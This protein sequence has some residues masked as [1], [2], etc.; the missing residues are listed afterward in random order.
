MIQDSPLGR[1]GNYPPEYTPELLFSID[2]AENRAALGIADELPFHGVDLWNAWELT[3]LGNNGQPRIACLE[4]RVPAASINIIES[5]SLK[6]YLNSF[7]MSRF[8]SADAVANRVATDLSRAAGAEVAVRLFDAAS[9]GDETSK[10]FPGDC[11]DDGDTACGTWQVDPNLLGAN[12]DTV[13]D[14]SLHSHLLRSLC[15]VTSQPDLGSVLIQYR[16]PA[17]DRAALLR[18][19]VSYRQHKDFQETCVERLFLDISERCKPERLTVYA[20]YQRRGGI[21]INPYRSNTNTD[22]ENIRL[23]RQ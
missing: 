18:Y 17:I 6:L 22:A 1:A 4:I 20:R 3:W 7:S 2:R 16:G 11:I 21:D 8:D 5:K 15:P 12:P 10:P 19:I 14:E 13:V 23:W 9:S